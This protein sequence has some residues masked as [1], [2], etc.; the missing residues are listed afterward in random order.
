MILAATKPQLFLYRSTIG[1][2]WWVSKFNLTRKYLSTN[3]NF[4]YEEK[5]KAQ[6]LSIFSYFNSNFSLRIPLITFP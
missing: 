6:N 5:E 3:L 1:F 4:F 2:Q